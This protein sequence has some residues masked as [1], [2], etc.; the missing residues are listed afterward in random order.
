MHTWLIKAETNSVGTH[1]AFPLA[2]LAVVHPSEG[3]TFICLKAVTIK[4]EHY[5]PLLSP[6]TVEQIACM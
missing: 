1:L 4:G 5:F 2:S 6:E 3:L